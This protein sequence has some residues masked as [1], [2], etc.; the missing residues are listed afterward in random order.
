MKYIKKIAGIVF[1]SAVVLLL[2]TSCGSKKQL[3]ETWTYEIEPVAVGSEGSYLIKVWSYAKKQDEA[4][5]KAKKNAIHG[6]LFRG[7]TGKSGVAGKA[8]LVNSKERETH[9]KY[10]EDFLKDGGGYLRFATLSNEGNIKSSDRIRVGKQYKIGV[11]VS[12]QAANLRRELEKNKI[13][14]SLDYGF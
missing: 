7:F 1:L 9:K 8:P 5:L 11:V 14:R 6:A 2:T 10:F 13:I 3:V 12:V 4:V